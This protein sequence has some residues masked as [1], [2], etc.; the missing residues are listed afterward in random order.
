MVCAVFLFAQGT[1]AVTRAAMI[2]ANGD[3]ELKHLLSA[4]LRLLPE[5]C[6]QRWVCAQPVSAQTVHKLSNMP[7]L[8]CTLL[9][10]WLL[11]VTYLLE[12][13]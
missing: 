7:A 2:M 11:A 8:C 4:S 9:H 1:A 5:H 6:E 12:G 13:C 3:T 10:E